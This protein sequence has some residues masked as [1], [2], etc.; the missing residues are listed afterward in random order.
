[1]ICKQGPE[2]QPHGSRHDRAP[3]GYSQEMRNGAEKSEI[4]PR[5]EQHEVRGARGDR[6]DDRVNAKGH[7][8]YGCH[9]S[10]SLALSFVLASCRIPD[11]HMATC[12]TDAGDPGTPPSWP[13]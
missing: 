11:D 6:G 5:C 13:A 10:S 7:N 3:H 8:N 9:D 1:M 4:C 12:E 2:P